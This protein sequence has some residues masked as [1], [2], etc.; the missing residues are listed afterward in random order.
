MTQNK[1]LI[2]K[3]VPT[4]L[5]VAGEHLAV[6]DRPID[7]DAA[8][9]DGLV[10][11]IVYASFD[12]YQRGRMR[13]SSK[14]SYSPAFE[15][16]GPVTNFTVSKVLKSKAPNFAEGDLV[17][18][19]TPIAEY[20]HVPSAALDKVR[21]VQ[22]PFNLDLALFLGPLGMPGLTA[23]SGLHKIGQPKTGETIFI[24]SAA[25]AV[26][27][28]VGQIAKREGLTVIGSVGSDEKLDFIV[29]ELGFDAGFNYKNEKPAD[30]LPRLA[31]NGIDIYFENVGGD[32]FEAALASMNFEGRIALC[33]M[34]SEYN[35]PA[36]QQKGIKGLTQLIA[37]QITLQGF[38]V[39]T[40]KF[41]PAYFME[42]QQNLQKWLSEGSVKAK[43]AVTEG[44]DNA[45]DGFIGMLTGKNFG[46]AVLKIK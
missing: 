40:P 14:K 13:D 21:K 24:S 46:K 35:T 1:T 33:G 11:E 19:L 16:D 12:P 38:L 29:K 44:I 26:G 23:W 4:G 20:A 32:H 27:Q 17:V 6:E 43:L 37:K 41:G 42:H 30:A 15:I 7:L 28:L 22:N 18:G 2:F 34:I 45:P 36:D 10:V 31:P 9:E 3:K 5:P 25:G 8:P 39:G